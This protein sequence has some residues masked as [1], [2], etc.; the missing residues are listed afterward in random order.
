MTGGHYVN[1]VKSAKWWRKRHADPEYPKG[2][3]LEHLFGHVCPDG[4]GS[5]GEGLTRSFE[6][7]RDE[8]RHA[9]SAGMVP[10]LPDHGVPENN[11]FRR[12]TS[13]DFAA[14]WR[15]V[16]SAAGDARAA[17][18]ADTLVE[19]VT[20][21][22]TSSAPSSRSRLP[23]GSP[24]GSP[25]RPSRPPDGTG[26]AASGDVPEP[27]LQARRALDEFGE[28]RIVQDWHPGIDGWIFQVD[29]TPGDLG[30]KF[31]IPAT[32]SWYIVAQPR[33]PAGLI[34]IMPAGEGGITD[35]F[36]HQ[37][38][39]VPARAGQ[40]YTMGK[41]CVATDSEGNLRSDREAEPIDAADRLA[42]HIVR[43]LEWI[44]RA[45]RG[46]LLADGDWFELPFIGM[47]MASSRSARG[48]RR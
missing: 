17:L 24:S 6:M 39:N 26:L 34:D 8:Y 36:P 20:R 5:V 48:P 12:I 25:C 32:T 1:I 37:L 4:I 41:I 40:P 15:L 3:P 13:Q 27:L 30:T 44:R 23:A 43:A 2:Y 35:T 16:E 21:W 42:W 19:S 33:Y 18:D 45:S 29:L 7:I 47:A 38:P 46:T 14:F 11:V 28:V 10:S 31:P 22:R 9:V